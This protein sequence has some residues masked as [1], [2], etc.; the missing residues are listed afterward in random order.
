MPFMEMSVRG[1]G[2]LGR[3]WWWR[4]VQMQLGHLRSV[5][6]WNTSSEDVNRAN[7]AQ[8]SAGLLD[9]YSSVV[10]IGFRDVN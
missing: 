4:R 7:S 3:R 10:F 2:A 5:Y 9:Y 6:V 8:A 1:L